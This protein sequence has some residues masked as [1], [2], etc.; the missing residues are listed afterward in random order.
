MPQSHA[1]VIAA[2]CLISLLL[3]L[4]LAFVL[5]GDEDTAVTVTL[6][7]S[8]LATTTQSTETTET[9]AET[10][11]TA[12][13]VWLVS[14]ERLELRHRLVPT[15]ETTTR[16]ATAALSTKWSWSSTTPPRHGPW[17]ALPS[18]D[19]AVRRRHFTRGDGLLPAR[20]AGGERL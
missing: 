3:G 17:F 11:Q 15:T 2:A 7:G 19:G 12:L 13:Q 18:R 1:W 8:T 5:D 10:A 9:T 4:A 14:G 6:P 16:T 20:G